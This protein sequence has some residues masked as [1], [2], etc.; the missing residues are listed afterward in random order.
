MD[1]LSSSVKNTTLSCVT[2]CAILRRET[3]TL[4]NPITNGH[5]NSLIPTLIFNPCKNFSLKFMWAVLICLKKIDVGDY[6][7]HAKFVLEPIL[8]ATSHYNLR[9]L[10]P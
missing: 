3:I 5:N 2:K 10:D 1:K 6:L 7:F 8:M 4:N 9:T